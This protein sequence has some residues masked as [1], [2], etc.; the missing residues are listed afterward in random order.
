[1][2]LQTDK[3][4]I[5]KPRAPCWFPSQRPAQ[6]RLLQSGIQ[7]NQNSVSVKAWQAD[8]NTFMGRLDTNNNAQM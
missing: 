3:V 7:L 2:A 5:V 1:M 4:G 8:S 6:A